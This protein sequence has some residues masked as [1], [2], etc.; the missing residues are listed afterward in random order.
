MVPVVVSVGMNAAFV[1]DL[2]RKIEDFKQAKKQKEEDQK[3][4]II[5]YQRKKRW[6]TEDSKAAE[7][8]FRWK[9]SRTDAQEKRCPQYMTTKHEDNPR[10]IERERTIEEMEQQL[11][12]Y[13]LQRHW[14]L[15]QDFIRTKAIPPIFYSPAHHNKKT[16]QMLAITRRKLNKKIDSLNVSLKPKHFVETEAAAK[17]DLLG[18]T[19][20]AP[21]LATLKET[22]QKSRNASSSSSH[23]WKP[24]DNN[25]QGCH[26][27]RNNGWNRGAWQ[28]RRNWKNAPLW[29]KN[30]FEHMTEVWPRHH[31]KDRGKHWKAIK[32]WQDG[33]C[34]RNSS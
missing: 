4:T 7:A 16:K 29:K 34:W 2:E 30:K 3:P 13:S 25:D 32:R 22:P 19:M 14:T 21:K 8:E 28:Q 9:T 31:N 26:K 20:A 15:M 27:D 24:S 1:R 11:L 17:H 18:R 10:A 12:Q 23:V 5:G 6:R 33:A